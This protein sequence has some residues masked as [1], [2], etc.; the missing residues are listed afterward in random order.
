MYI[1]AY[2]TFDLPPFPRPDIMY[3]FLSISSVPVSSSISIGKL[4]NTDTMIDV[5]R[6]KAPFFEF[7]HNSVIKQTRQ[8]IT[9]VQSSN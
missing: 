2:F 9:R 8:I 5:I 4:L 7:L 3:F 6:F 1:S